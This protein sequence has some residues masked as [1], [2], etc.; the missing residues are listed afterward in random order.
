MTGDYQDLST[1]VEY[2]LFENAHGDSEPIS[3]KASSNILRYNT[4]RTTGGGFVSRA[5]NKNECI[6]NFFLQGGVSG[7]AG[8]RL[9]EKDHVVYNNYIENTANE[10]I[11]AYSGDPYDGAFTHAQ[12]FR[13]RVVHNTVVVSGRAVTIGGGGNVLPPQDCVFANARPFRHF[14]F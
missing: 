3:V 12:V 6:G 5:G 14:E 1:I 8:V 9:H 2:N 11:N 7:S 13:A 4:V 10:P